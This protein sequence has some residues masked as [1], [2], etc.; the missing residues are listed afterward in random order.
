MK[1]NRI[2][3]LK[4]KKIVNFVSS[5]YVIVSI[6]SLGVVVRLALINILPLTNDEGFYFYD[7]YLI[8]RGFLPYRDFL[9]K[10]LP[11]I[12]SLALFTFIFGNSILGGRIMTIFLFIGNC[13]LLYILVKRFV[14]KEA[15]LCTVGI[16]SFYPAILSLTSYSQTQQIQLFFELLFLLFFIKSIKGQEF[17]N[18]LLS[19][20]F[21]TLANFART[22]TVVLLVN[23]FLVFFIFANNRK[24]FLR[25]FVLF[26]IFLLVINAIFLLIF[27]RVFGW[28]KAF[29]VY[30]FGV[31]TQATKDY[32]LVSLF[33]RYFSQAVNILRILFFFPLL[34]VSFFFIFIFFS[35]KKW[36]WFRYLLKGIGIGIIFGYFIDTFSYKFINPYLFFLRLLEGIVALFLLTANYE[37]RRRISIFER[38]WAGWAIFYILSY[39][40]W[41]KFRAPYFIESFPFL[42][43][44]FSFIFDR[45]KFKKRFISIVL[46]LFLLVSLPRSFMQFYTGTIPTDLAKKVTTITRNNSSTEEYI[47]TASSLYAFLSE[48]Q[49]PFNI[50]HPTWYYIKDIDRNL[51]Y[52]YLPPFKQVEEWVLSNKPVIIIRDRLTDEVYFNQSNRL[53]NLLNNEYDVIFEARKV[54]VYKKRINNF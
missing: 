19:S 22:T 49:L 4:W 26:L 1:K 51:F 43:V 53:R 18:I 38:V 47:F 27:S 33:K 45:L 21:F 23:V 48:R 8:R 37:Y 25:L 24:K 54:K 50:S 16:F 36:W 6:L 30:G 52:L 14:K 35:P 13:L 46:F 28:E 44:S 20:F 11:H 40:N 29:D 2:V 12:Y 10:S 17:I 9:T 3:R 34:T 31:I 5:N 15:A 7:A 39:L 42:A 41:V 32:A